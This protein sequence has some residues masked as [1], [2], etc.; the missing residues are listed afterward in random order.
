M[1]SSSFRPPFVLASDAPRDQL[2]L[3]LL[4]ATIADTAPRNPRRRSKSVNRSDRAEALD[5]FKIQGGS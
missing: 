3:I 5:G 1:F 4:R 2:A